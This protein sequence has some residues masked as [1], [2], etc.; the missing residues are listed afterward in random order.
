MDDESLLEQARQGDSGAF[1]SLVERYQDELYTMALRLLG[2]PADAA[3][4]VQETFLRA[5]MNLPRLRAVSVRGWL[6]RVAVNAR[7]DVQR[8]PIRRP[9]DPLDQGDGQALAL[10]PP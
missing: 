10:P 3:D 6:F 9:A 2:T 1:T 7:R 4:V 8:P 5:Y